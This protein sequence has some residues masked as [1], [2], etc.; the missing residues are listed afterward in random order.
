MK[1]ATARAW[2]A[3]EMKVVL[4]RLLLEMAD[5]WAS[6][7]DKTP[8]ERCRGLAFSILATFDGEGGEFP[9]ISLVLR[10]HEDDKEYHQGR[11]E[12]WIEDGTVIDNSGN[13]HNEWGDF[14]AWAETGRLEERA[15]L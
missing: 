8:R 3:N 6:Y 7:P 1:V 14:V 4:L 10:P 12:N 11:D 15:A 13:L 9:A 2:T 5:E